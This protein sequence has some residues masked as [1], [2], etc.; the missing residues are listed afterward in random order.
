M[1]RKADLSTR[2]AAAAST[3]FT[4]TELMIVRKHSNDA[5]GSQTWFEIICDGYLRTELYFFDFYMRLM[6]YKAL[7][8]M[9][10]R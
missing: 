1:Q 3:G 8:C 7:P 6:H 5:H 4:E 9:V 2:Q 10:Q